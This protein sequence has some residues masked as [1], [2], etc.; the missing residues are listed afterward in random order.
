MEYLNLDTQEPITNIVKTL[1]GEHNLMDWSY[2]KPGL[3]RRHIPRPHHR[4][5]S[6]H[7]MFSSVWNNLHSAVFK[8]QLKNKLTNHTSYS[9]S[10][11]IAWLCIG[12]VLYVYIYFSVYI[13]ASFG[14]EL[15]HIQMH[16][17]KS[18]LKSTLQIEV[19]SKTC[20]IN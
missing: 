7:C 14:E 1:Q 6:S 20:W 5:S 19:I 18:L 17:P 16:D 15:Y 8:A 12:L 2:E 13:T 4:C 11:L 3:S 10:V 9:N